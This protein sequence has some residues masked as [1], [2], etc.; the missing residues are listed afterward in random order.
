MKKG[1]QLLALLLIGCIRL[2][3]Q[4]VLDQP[5]S[6]DIRQ[7]P[8]A[9]AFYQ[10][11]EREGVPLSF[12]ND[13]LPDGNYTFRYTTR[14]LR[15]V[16][17][18]VLRNT[19][20]IYQVQE[21]QIFILPAEKIT[22]AAATISGY[23]YDVETG[24]RLIGAGIQDVI[25]QRGTT[26]N[27]YGFFSLNL[28]TGSVNLVVSYLGY[29][30][31]RESLALVANQKRNIALKGSITLNEVIVYA[32]DTLA[33]PIGG[34][35][36]GNLI[37]LRETQ[38]LPSLAG[39]P[40]IFRTAH[41]LPGVTTGADG[42]EGLQVRGGDAGQN[43]V[44]LD[45]VPVYYVNHAIGLFSVFNSNAIRSARLL[46]GGFPARYAGR[47]SSVLDVRMKEGNRQKITGSAEAGL[48]STRFLLE[49]PVSNERSSFLVSGRWSFVHALLVPESRK[50]KN[51]NGQDGQTDYRFYDVNAKFN[52]SFSQND[53]LYLS[54]YKGRDQYDDFTTQSNLL[55][56]ID[57]NG[58]LLNFNFDQ[59][60][61]EGLTWGNTVGSLRWNHLFSNRV[62]ANFSVTYSGLEQ[63]SFYNQSDI[64]TE[65]SISFSDSV[66]VQGL[67]QSG[68]QDAGIKAD[69][70]WMYRHNLS[71]RAGGGANRR[72]FNPGALVVNEPLDGNTVPFDNNTIHTTEL[73]AYL[74]GEG[75]WHDRWTWNAGLHGAWWYARRQ[76]RP[77]LQPRLSI[78]YAATSN[79]IINASWSRMVQPLHFLRNNTLNLPTEIWV[80]STDRIA[81][82]TASL[83]SLGWR[84]EI[85]T[86][87]QWT[88]DLYYKKMDGL[89]AFLEGVE[90][91]RNWED[92]VAVGQGLAYGAEL[93]LNK[94]AG[95]LTGWISY[96][97]ARADRQFDALNLG[98]TY[99]FRYD[100]R[101]NVQVAAVYQITTGL[102]A[103]ANWGYSTGFALTLP[104]VKFSAVV[105]GELPPPG[106]LPFVLDPEA[107]NNVRMPAN[108]RLDLNIHYTWQKKRL[109]HTLNAGLYNAYNRNN[110]LYYDVRRVLV[111]QN[112]VLVTRYNFVEVQLTP[113]LPTISYRLGF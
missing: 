27:E 65:P 47:L 78:N 5:V 55:D 12:R 80:P 96:T 101:H 109:A 11:I 97:L 9:E 102:Y 4:Q 15:E 108:H 14:P 81:P 113:M 100:R 40:D 48:L 8:I 106:G 45:G 20:L 104:L 103:S 35:A 70:Q 21:Q 31:H 68:I 46:R 71:F 74:E 36:T 69:V 17:E 53:H 1:G 49:G 76:G 50:F 91:F 39:E 57:R 38:L 107:K 73:T 77:N 63:E 32:R 110:P 79:W 83:A 54:F 51:R 3:A 34:L 37:G 10:L 86:Q 75:Q 13:I 89:V 62:F 59:S 56:L 25:S 95:R 41:L 98:R 6:L 105:P 26:S 23:V 19:G 28:P 2:S 87:W 18:G 90:G 24:E 84:H 67:F 85:S 58:T 93:Q 29:E 60:Y 44:L 99:P 22:L 33:D 42:A 43:L 111:N 16:L 112:N 72:I 7:Q 82:A 66:H 88:G 52:Y 64:L 92:H 94:V 61:A 30:S